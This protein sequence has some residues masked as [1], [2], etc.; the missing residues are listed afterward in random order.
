MNHLRAI[1]DIPAEWRIYREHHAK[2]IAARLEGKSYTMPSRHPLT[3]T[4]VAL[5]LLVGYTAGLVLL[6]ICIYLMPIPTLTFVTLIWFAISSI[7]I[8]EERGYAE[9]ERRKGR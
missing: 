2:L 7:T 1:L 4:F 5:G 9:E 6:S 8:Y 3:F